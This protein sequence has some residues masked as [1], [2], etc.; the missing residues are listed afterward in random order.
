MH[1][2]RQPSP[3]GDAL[4]FPVWLHKFL[5]GSCERSPPA[6]CLCGTVFKHPQ[7][8]IFSSVARFPKLTRKIIRHSMKTASRKVG[9][10]QSGPK[11]ARN[12]S[13][14]GGQVDLASIL[15]IETPARGN[16]MS[17]S[18]DSD[19]NVQDDS[20]G[21]FAMRQNRSNQ[22]EPQ[23][24]CSICDRPTTQTAGGVKEYAYSALLPVNGYVLSQM[25]AYPKCSFSVSPGITCE[26]CNGQG[27]GCS[28]PMSSR[29]RGSR[30]VKK[31]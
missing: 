25:K 22:L 19:L 17:L 7:D 9:K 14:P 23:L 13:M 8:N 20:G 26:R 21:Y 11:A 10:G 1:R 24:H 4:F 5:I 16:N 12:V 28:G 30:A 6:L 18:R 15:S 31:S 3:I 27:I 29:Q 2:P